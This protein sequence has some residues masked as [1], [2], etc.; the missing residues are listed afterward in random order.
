[1]LLLVCG[2]TLSTVSLVV[3]GVILR[4]APKASQ[5][6]GDGRVIESASRAKLVIAGWLV[7]LFVGLTVLAEYFR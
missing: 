3:L 7:V 1:M 5:A 6:R 2:L 4:L